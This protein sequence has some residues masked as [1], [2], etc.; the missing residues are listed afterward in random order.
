MT[1]RAL[2]ERAA[3]A[4][5]EP[6][7]RR[8][9][10]GAASVGGVLRAHEHRTA[11]ALL[12]LLVLVYLWPVLVG[13]DVLSPGSL[14]WSF[15]PWS[16]SMPAARAHFYNQLLS[17]VPT[18]YYPWDA[19][20]RSMLRSG[21][22]PAWN[23]HAFAGTPFFANLSVAWLGPFSLPLWILPL[24]YALGLSAALKLW[25]AAFGTY[26]LV[27]ELRLGFWPG[28]LAGTSFA[29]CAFDVVWLTHQAHVAVAVLLPWLVWLAERIVRR[30]GRAEGVALA[31][32]VAAALGGGHPGTQ[33]HVLAGTVLY[34][35]VRSATVSGIPRGERL[36]RLA[37]VAGGIAVGALLMAVVLVPG[38]RAALGT[39][40]EAA[41]RNGGVGSSLDVLPLRS[42]LA[43]AFPD[44]WGRP[45][46]GLIAG[47]A[48]YNERAFYAGTVALL[49]A[50]M[51]LVSPG[52]RRR[53]APFL[54]LAALGLAV[55][56]G[57]P[58]VRSFVVG[59]PGFDR[60]LDQRLLLWL[61]FAV[62]VLGAFGLD[63]ALRA[64]RRQ[65]RAWVVVA[66]ALAGGAVAI[67]A[68]A[69]APGDVAGAFR[70]LTDR[71]A[72]TTP[73]ALALASVVR[74]LAL[75]AG[76]ALALALLRA[77]PRHPWLAGGLVALLAALDMLA[78]AH[79]YQPMGPSAI[80]LPPRTP[81]IVYLQRHAGEQRIAGLGPALTSDWS[82]LYGLRDARG[83]DAPQPDERFYR[84]WTVL[85]EEQV[86]W[87]P[88][89]ISAL[90]PAGLRVLGVLGVRYVVTDPGATLPA[91]ADLRPLS[92][93][94]RGR[95]AT[96][97]ANA[98]AAPRALVARRV[99][100]A[101]SAIGAVQAAAAAG[102][103]PR[104]DAIVPRG[105][106]GPHPP[107][108]APG[109]SARVV[110]EADARVVLDATLTRRGLVVLDDA[111]APGWSVAVDGRPARALQADVVMRGVVVPAGRHRIV[112]S[113]RVPG[114]QL[115]A[116]LSA[117][118]LLLLLGWAGTLRARRRRSV[119]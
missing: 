108:G 19:L 101:G 14:L 23:P 27:R 84:L 48:N 8:L 86:A 7:P 91:E 85:S 15:P 40:G 42:L 55:P 62:A 5:R 95:D 112:W 71:F 63:A 74:A 94:Y 26:L 73:G 44:W 100:L 17:D 70:H 103:D 18:S 69:L 77:Q 29:L 24:N 82:T 56:L 89:E 81:A 97:F 1:S 107:A 21:T 83:Y 64:P 11:A 36:V 34:A 49:F 88:F 102:F 60:V 38:E 76:V 37:T 105:A 33:V 96:V 2:G 41:R 43:A 30:G 117:L 79:G 90:S 12:A 109:G 22:F 104:R 16:A 47:P 52:G 65:L 20:A 4:D 50:A 119:R 114:L 75:V 58:L 25:V 45:S 59:L 61:A 39:V 13:G 110:A 80:V 51:A 99:R 35:L 6:E 10:A 106:F 32:V 78:F 93:A 46:E 3:N 111:W 67:H 118:G 28:L 72:G 116:A 9:R 87:K 115:G 98:L 113:Y 54:P 66:V 68:I 53:K 31:L 92:T 57:A